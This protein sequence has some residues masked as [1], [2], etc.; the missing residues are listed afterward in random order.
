[1]VVWVVLADIVGLVQAAFLPV[2][3]KLL[4]VDTV[5]DP[6]K[7]HGNGF[8]LFLLDGVIGDA[9]RRVVVCVNW[10]WWLWVPN[11]LQCNEE[12]ACFFCIVEQAS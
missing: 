12:R 6:V 10:G 8:G 5:A 3:D 7:L 1:M 4:V 2:Y 11:F 9:G